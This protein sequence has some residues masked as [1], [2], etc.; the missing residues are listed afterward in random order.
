MS[1][2][3]PAPLVAR[4]EA[5]AVGALAERLPSA[6]RLSQVLAAGA[7]H[8]AKHKTADTE[9]PAKR[10][11]QEDIGERQSISRP[12]LGRRVD[13]INA[14]VAAFDAAAEAGASNATLKRMVD[15]IHA[16]V[17]AIAEKAL[18]VADMEVLR[19]SGAYFVL[20][21]IWQNGED[22]L[23]R[24]NAELILSEVLHGDPDDVNNFLDS[25]H[26]GATVL[27]LADGPVMAIPERH[28]K[29]F[30]ERHNKERR[31][32]V[33]EEREALRK[34]QKTQEV[35]PELEVQVQAAQDAEGMQ[36]G[37]IVPGQAED[38]VANQQADAQQAAQA[39]IDSI[40]DGSDNGDA[41]DDEEDNFETQA[42]RP[43]R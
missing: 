28:K 5:L 23:Q 36:E 4:H 35:S 24:D 9:A 29:A 27:G 7:K 39:A 11:L 38:Q 1:V 40:G 22:R 41:T 2:R 26:E 12:I 32:K 21:W 15:E 42:P 31:G 13:A 3:R 8:L 25:L 34:K 16:M 17:K 14:K 30:E 6:T 20:N 18:T 37:E 19:R 10:K 43:P 33:E